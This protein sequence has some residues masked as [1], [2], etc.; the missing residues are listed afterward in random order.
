MKGVYVYEE[1]FYEK[2]FVREHNVS[3]FFNLGISCIVNN[4]RENI[5]QKFVWSARMKGNV[6]STK[7][8]LLL[9]DFCGD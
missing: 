7:V 3:R 2:K 8:Y 9:L 6:I 1:K 4:Q 5:L